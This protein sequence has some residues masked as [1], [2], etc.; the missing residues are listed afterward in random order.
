MLETLNLTN[1]LFLD[2]ETVSQKKHFSE[3]DETMQELWAHKAKSLLRKEENDITTED[4]EN[5]YGKAAIYAE[6]G[7]II[8]I[9]VGF[10][11]Q[12]AETGEFVCRLKSFRGHDEKSLITDFVGLLEKAYNNP[13]RHYLCGHN[14][15]EFDIPY[16]C[17][18][19]AI[20]R[21]KLPRIL[22]IAGKKPWETKFLLD[23][24]ELWK[25]GDNKNY[26]SIKLLAAIFGFPS[27]KDDIDGSQ[28]GMVYWQ[29]DDVE[30][31]AT[32]CE[33]DVLAVVQLILCFKR[34]NPLPPEQV[35]FVK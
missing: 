35:I 28:V 32:Y 6:F 13:D 19:M 8:C 3:L 17:R 15:K 16:I 29:E 21:M 5:C 2:I 1:I 10:L 12:N 33:K 25:F 23:T 34:M 20:H 30:R 31:I 9:S 27:P 22:D 4:L 14:I 7:K 26:T 24:L 11:T 18:R